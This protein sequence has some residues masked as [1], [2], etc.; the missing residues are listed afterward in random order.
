MDGSPQD[1]MKGGREHRVPLSERVLALLESPCREPASVCF[2]AHAVAP[3]TRT[4]CG[5]YCAAC[6]RA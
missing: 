2:P 1:R 4:P 5:P 3:C 6:D